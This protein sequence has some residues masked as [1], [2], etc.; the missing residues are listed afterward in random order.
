V[1]AKDPKMAEA[2]DHEV[3]KDIMQMCDSKRTQWEDPDFPA[4]DTSLFKSGHNTSGNRIEWKRPKDF[5]PNP[6]L[7]IDGVESGDVIQGALGD[8][9][10]L[11]ALSV[12]ATRRDLLLP[13]FV[14][15]HE[16][17]GFYQIKF[18]KNGEWKVV[19]IDDR[20]PLYGSRPIYSHCKDKN[21]IWVPL[22][23]K[24]YAKLHRCYEVLDTGSLA[25]ALSDLTG[26][27]TQ[28]FN[29][30][31]AE[32]MRQIYNGQLWKQLLYFVSE[33][34]LMGCTYNDATGSAE[35]D[36]GL[37]ILRN[38][39]YGLLDCKEPDPG[40]K[41]LS[42]RNPWGH[43]EWRGRF[44]DGSSDWTPSLIK[45]LDVKFEDDGTFWMCFEDFIK[46]FTGL[47]VL[48]LLTDDIGK[49]WD[50]YVYVD[51]WNEK[52]AGGSTNY[53]TWHNNPQYGIVVNSPDTRIF[54]SLCQPDQRMN[55]NS[56]YDFSLGLNLVK[57]TDCKR[58]KFSIDNA[59]IVVKMNY[60][61]TRD[62]SMAAVL[63]PG[64]YILFPA[65]FDPK[66]QTKFWLTIYSENPI[67]IQKVPDQKS[68]AIKGEWRGSTAGGCYNSAT[69]INNPKFL[70]TPATSPPGPV[71]VTLTLKQ[72]DRNPL[73]YLGIYSC[74]WE[75]MNRL[76]RKAV[77][78]TSQP[79][80][81]RREIAIELTIPP[82][83]FPYVL[84]PHTFDAGEDGTFELSAHCTTPMNLEP[85]R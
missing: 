38:H 81:N 32:I 39:A 55:W 30:D 69:W 77:H 68:A 72:P 20:I 40:L 6:Q 14:S 70:L 53:P 17:Q 2:A 61:N 15:A 48:C 21:E 37:G 22:M 41:L 25:A 80:V 9:Y 76:D 74:H 24:A 63:Q 83:E 62:V 51:E 31:D 45:K 7:F 78:K 11:G 34:F 54:F 13:L 35:D 56:K 8:C 84:I 52:T 26:E 47:Y 49:K 67:S 85:L 50:K 59:D 82:Y 43:L 3:A 66:Q 29:F 5:C 46:Q 23:E 36:T 75:G 27:S 18:F 64:Q 71:T 58:K 60:L 28:I 1:S 65:T 57:T 44:S 4:N 33:N 12:V 19:T 16:K 79:C 73:S 10:F 42:V